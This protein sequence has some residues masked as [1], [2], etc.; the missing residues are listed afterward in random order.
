[1]N[2]NEMIWDL[3]QLVE[4]TDTTSIQ[5]KLESMVT[6]AEK[7]RKKYHGKIVGLDAKCVLELLETKDAYILKFEG[8]NKYCR[9]MY[10]ADS[11]DAVAKQLNDAARR[12]YTKVGQT[13]AFIEIELGKLLAQK[14]HWSQTQDSQSTSTILK[15]Y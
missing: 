9:L 10:S 2:K 5:K 12:A 13:L 8:V 15:E 3:S 1:M 7:I 4:R 14:P 11:T 6:E